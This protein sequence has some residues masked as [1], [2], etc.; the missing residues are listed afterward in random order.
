MIDDRRRML[1]GVPVQK[2]DV[3]QVHFNSSVGFGGSD[4]CNHQRLDINKHDDDDVTGGND[5]LVL[6]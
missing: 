5:V 2:I 4:T 1:R 3:R 6:W